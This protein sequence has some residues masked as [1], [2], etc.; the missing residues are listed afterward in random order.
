MIGEWWGVV[1]FVIG[2]DVDCVVWVVW[3]VFDEGWGWICL[4]E[5]VKF[6]CCFVDLFLE[7]V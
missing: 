2:N 3:C 5:R 4:F 6:L 1:L 7:D